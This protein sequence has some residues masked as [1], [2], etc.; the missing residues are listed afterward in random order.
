[1]MI[2]LNGQK[3]KEIIKIQKMDYSRNLENLFLNFIL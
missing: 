1:M 2:K 3:L